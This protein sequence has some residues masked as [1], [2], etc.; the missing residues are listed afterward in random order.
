MSKK[1]LKFDDVKVNKKE[2]HAFKNVISLNLV[3]IDKIVISDQFKQ[4][5]ID[6]LLVTKKIMLLRIYALFCL[7]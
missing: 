7:R 1:T 6:I 3:D 5:D 4:S 2:F